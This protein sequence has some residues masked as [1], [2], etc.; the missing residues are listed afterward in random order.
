[1]SGD[2]GEV[3]ILGVGMHPW[4]KWGRNFVEYGVHAAQAA[5]ADAGV[6][7]DA[8]CSSSPA[9]RRSATAT[10]ATSPALDLRAGARLD[11]RAGRE[12]LRRV[13]VGQP[14]D[15]RGARADPRRAL[16][17]R[18]RGR[19][20]H[21]AEGLPRAAAGGE[22]AHDPDWLRFRLLGAT[23]PIYFGLYARRR[24]DLYGAT[25]RDFAQVKVKNSRHG[26]ANPNARY[27]KIVHARR[28]CSPRRWSPTR[29]ACSRSA[30]PATAARR[31]CCRAWSTRASARA[32][33][34]AI[35]AVSTVTPRYPEHR[36]RDAELRDRL[37]GRACAAPDVAFKD[38]IAKRGLRG[39]GPRAR[40]RRAS[41]RSTTS[42]RR[43]S[44]TGT[45][46]SGCASPARPRSCCATASRRSAAAMPVNP[47]GGLGVLRRG[48]PGA[49]DRAGVRAHLAA[50]R[51][52]RRAARSR[53]P[54]SASRAN[55]GLFGHGSS[56]IVKA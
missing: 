55:Q 50:A 38:S 14:G 35:A 32:K 24:M 25:E 16:R 5:L 51:P 36:D 10:R 12:H 13:R 56:V 34:V 46:T 44:S 40:G 47:S 20:R 3:A 18:A 8:T 28:R 17:R 49:G 39:G 41:P 54:A 29:C 33:P 42:R 21:H 31:S 7:V 11:R 43:S 53:A 48:D 9:A 1:M 23:N 2:S 22:R 19:R 4:G 37:G 27:R 6:D 45:R 30:P 26:L 15:R 52:G